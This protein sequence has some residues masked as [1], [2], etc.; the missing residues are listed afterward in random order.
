MGGAHGDDRLPGDPVRERRILGRDGEA[1]RQHRLVRRG[2]EVLTE[3]VG[4]LVRARRRERRH[5]VHHVRA[6]LVQPELER[7]DDAEVRSGAAHSPEEIGT[8]RLAHVE[9]LAVGGDE[10]DRE[11]IVDRE[12]EPSLK[13]AHAATERE[14]RDPRVADHAHR[15]GEAERLGLPVQL[16]Q[17]RPAVHLRRPALGIDTDAPH[18]GEIDHDP[19]VAGREAADAMASRADRDRDVLVTSEADRSDHVVHTVASGDDR[20]AP[21]D[22]R[23]PHEPGGVVAGA[24]RKHDLP[25]EGVAEWRQRGCAHPCWCRLARHGWTG[26][27]REALT[28]PWRSGRRAARRA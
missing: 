25:Q 1:E 13:P 16:P 11:E 3:A 15:A 28:A 24:A 6:D 23:I 18:Q 5:P 4:D 21:V 17:E 10:L 26:C 12:A 2:R 20:R 14:P 8:L 9:E 22:H 27:H 7:G 19:V